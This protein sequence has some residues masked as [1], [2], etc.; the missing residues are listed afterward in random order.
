[1]YQKGKPFVGAKVLL[2]GGHHYVV[3]KVEEKYYW[4]RSN[5]TGGV[6]KSGNDT[7]LQHEEK[8]FYKTTDYIKALKKCLQPL[9]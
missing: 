2:N 1:M 9:F 7:F 4:W 8:P 6:Y 5:I 3:E